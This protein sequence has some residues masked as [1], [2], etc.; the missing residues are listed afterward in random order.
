[1]MNVYRFGKPKGDFKVVV[2]SNIGE[3]SKRL[4]NDFEYDRIDVVYKDVIV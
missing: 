2:A 3:A 1:M 4:P